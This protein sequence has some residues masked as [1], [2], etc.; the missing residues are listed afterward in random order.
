M[1][2]KGPGDTNQQPLNEKRS[3]VLTSGF[4]LAVGG[5]AAMGSLS[6]LSLR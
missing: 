2:L 6:E 4:G 5:H 3:N 1:A